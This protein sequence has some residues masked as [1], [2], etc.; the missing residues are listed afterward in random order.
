[1]D[2]S[3]S[4]I[5][6]LE[7]IEHLTPQEMMTEEV[8]YQPL[9]ER[10][11]VIKRLNPSAA[12]N[13]R[14]RSLF[15]KEAR[16]LASLRHP[17]IVQVYDAAVDDNNLPYAVLAKPNG[18]RLQQRL[19]LLIEPEARMELKEVEEVILGVCE[20]VEFSHHN[21]VLLNDLSPTN[22][23]LTTSGRTVLMGLGQPPPGEILTAPPRMLTYAS[24]ERL[25][26]GRVDTRSDIYSLGVL[27][28]HL[29]FGCLP[30]EGSALKII[31][32][33]QNS[34]SLPPLEDPNIELLESSALVHVLRQA[35]DQTL[36]R[37]YPDVNAFRT[38]ITEAFSV[39]ST[40]S[41]VGS[42]ISDNGQ[43]E[44]PGETGERASVSLGR[45]GR[46]PPASDA[47]MAGHLVIAGNGRDGKGQLEEIKEDVQVSQRKIEPL[48]PGCDEPSLR[49]ALSYTTLVP[50]SEAVPEAALEAEGQ[51]GPAMASTMPR[52]NWFNPTWLVWVLALGI[53]AAIAALTLG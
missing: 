20:A 18:M 2:S 52:E 43:N 11:V 3:I 47:E 50:M 44:R 53:S 34:P 41:K 36:N 51:P 42:T 39:E 8:G 17:N 23:F 31:A 26:G 45:A 38:A 49:A 22:I 6:D 27:V 4:L 1:M 13:V 37:R 33:K 28:Y 12:D 25:F 35:T 19:D 40:L 9:L 30:F 7:F 10:E 15:I 14:L 48:M 5:K 29:I 21:N 24:P 32:R 16:I 46:V